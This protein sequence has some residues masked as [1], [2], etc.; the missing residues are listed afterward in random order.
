MKIAIA[1]LV[2]LLSVGAASAITTKECKAIKVEATCRATA[3]CV[4]YPLQKRCLKWQ[5]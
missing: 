5:H 2:L 3:G 1:V 4:W